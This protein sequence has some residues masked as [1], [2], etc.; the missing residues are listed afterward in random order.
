MTKKKVRRD[1]ALSPF[2]ALIHV[3][4]ETDDHSHLTSWSK[5]CF[6]A[7]VSHPSFSLARKSKLMM[8]QN[9]KASTQSVMNP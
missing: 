3:H 7:R 4:G 6:L 1:P 2:V 5:R 9:C 8:M